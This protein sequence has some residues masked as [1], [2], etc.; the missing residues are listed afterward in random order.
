[1]EKVENNGILIRS[2]SADDAKE[3][4]EIY[5]PYVINTAVSFEYAPPTI[6]IFKERICGI[7][8]KY[9]YLVS[10]I[11]GKALG[12][13]YAKSFNSREAY[14][15]SVEV[16]VYVASSE[17][18]RGI[19]KTLYG[20]LEE[21]LKKIGITNM[22]AYI[23]FCPDND[24]KLNADSLYFHKKL[25]FEE[26]GHLKKCGYKFNRYYDLIIMEKFIK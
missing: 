17:R 25:G 21:E 5:T 24:I 7:S 10:T 15:Y 11:N 1:M 19:G 23:A 8:E 20:V 18:R 16:S 14:K 12:Y 26:A 13:A 4:L 2:A 6:D 9:P 3:L 22:Y